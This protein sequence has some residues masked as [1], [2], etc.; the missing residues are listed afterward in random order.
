VIEFPCAQKESVRMIEFPCAQKESVRSGHE[1][2]CSLGKGCNYTALVASCLSR[3]R[4]LWN[5]VV[6][7]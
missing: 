1:H 6:C 7:C 3:W 4:R 5:T 2:P